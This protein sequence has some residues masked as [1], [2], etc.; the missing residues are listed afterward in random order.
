MRCQYCSWSQNQHDPKCPKRPGA[1]PWELE[2]WERGYRDGRQGKICFRD[3]ERPFGDLYQMG[4]KQ[5]NVALEEAQNG[6]DPRF[7]N[8]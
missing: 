5:G 6:F 8:G 1:F 4:W 3:A 2:Y 7:D